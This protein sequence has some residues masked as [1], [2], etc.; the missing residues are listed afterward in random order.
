MAAIPAPV[1]T[2]TQQKDGLT[3]KAY[4]GDACVLLAMSMSQSQ[5][6]GLAGFA[7]ARSIDAG[8]TWTYIPNRLSFDPA[9]GVTAATDPNKQ[10]AQRQTSDIAPFQKFRW[11]DFPPDTISAP[12]MYRVEAKFFAPAGA[13]GNPAGHKLTTG[14]SVTV[15]I[16]LHGDVYPAFQIGFTRGYVSSQAFAEKFGAITSMRP[17]RSVTFSTLAPIAGVAP[18]QTWRSMYQWLGGDARVILNGFLTQCESDKADYDVFAYDLDEPDFLKVL[19]RDAKAGRK[20]RMVLDDAPLHTKAGA[21]EPAAAALLQSAG[22][23]IKRG[24]FARFAHDKCIIERD[25]AGKAVRVLTGS[26][27]FSI[28]GL[29]VQSNSIIRINDPDVAALYGQAFDQAWT[30]MPAFPKSPIAAKWF[31]ATGSGIPKF[32]VSF[33]PH[34]TGAVSL[35]RVAAAIRNAKS[36]VLFAVMELAGSG[37][38]MSEL[39]TLQQRPDI[40]SYGVTQTAGGLK[41]YKGGGT[42]GLLVPFGYLAAHVPLPFRAEW[43]GGAGQV[44]H[45]KFVVVDFNGDNP[46]VFCGSSNLAE[47]GEQ[48]NGDNMLAITDPAIATLYAVEA[49][50]L[51]D[52]YEFR[53][54]EQTATAA[55]PMLLQGPSAATTWWASS[56]DS[57]N[58]KNR[59]RLLFSS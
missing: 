56:F 29:Y 45:H 22:V 57:A 53:A 32:S 50:K 46:Q 58:I 25:T 20:I 2:V 26:A 40:F 47:G 33:A 39:T 31:D 14:A 37:A 52:H 35:D 27:N 9:K 55:A 5:C 30:S 3:V 16:A 28:R 7:I 12:Y 24:H 11:I 41:Y 43:S 36:S 42:N 17:A 44:I 13:A 51:V 54:I 59:E 23:T 1:T 8:K 18:P 15:T 49:I 10:L 4:R 19:V 38:V 34:T 21:L 48:A 6:A